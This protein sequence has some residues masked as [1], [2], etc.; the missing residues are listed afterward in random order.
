MAEEGCVALSRGDAELP[1]FDPRFSSTW[2]SAPD[3][4]PKGGVQGG[5]W[6][7]GGDGSVVYRSK[8]GSIILC[9]VPCERG[10][11]ACE[12][13]HDCLGEEATVDRILKRLDKGGG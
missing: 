11:K 3:T 4:R 6:E 5:L 8:R 9:E 2:L 12:N 10:G 13:L 1:A 7:N